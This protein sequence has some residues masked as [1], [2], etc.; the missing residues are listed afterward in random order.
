[1]R[2]HPFRS[3]YP[4]QSLLVSPD[5]FFDTMG[6]DFSKHFNSGLFLENKKPCI[7][8]YQISKGGKFY[9]GIVNNTSIHDLLEGK[10]LFHENTIKNKE[11]DMVQSSLERK[12]MIKPVLL[13][14]KK[15]KKIS[16]FIDT[17]LKRKRFYECEL[18]DGTIHAFWQVQETRKIEE[19]RQ[20]FANEISHAYI[21][22][23]HH[24]CSITKRLFQN[25]SDQFKDLNFD[26]M[27]SAYFSV[28]Q[29]EI[30]DHLKIVSILDTLKP[31]V[32]IARL[33]RFA[34]IKHVKKFKYP[35]HKYE[36]I[37]LMNKEIYQASWKIDV[38]RKFEKKGELLGPYVMNEVV[39]KKIFE[40]EDLQKDDRISYM[41][42]EEPPEKIVKACSKKKNAITICQ[43]PLSIQDIMDTA[44][45]G[46]K[47]PPKS[48]WF[49]PRIKSGVIAQK[50]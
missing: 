13:F 45:K 24:R 10:I 28:D 48:T 5:S 7:Y 19:L 44:D 18:E 37:I 32:F 50:Y 21:A 3:L 47:L 12:A 34:K 8:I 1:M 49:M 4:N 38:L 36:F 16:N 22:D 29:L 42:G 43:F 20:L 17:I 31:E 41:S 2:I 33:S 46:Q 39:F 27:L 25:K 15:S 9:N 23:G 6:K 14:H 30:Y 26:S 35:Q 40:I 11:Q